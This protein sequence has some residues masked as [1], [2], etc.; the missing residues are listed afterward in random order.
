MTTIGKLV[1]LIERLKE[2]NPSI[3][4]ELSSAEIKIYLGQALNKLL[5]V[6]QLNVNRPDSENFPPHCMIATYENIPVFPY[7]VNRSYAVLPAYPISLP[8]NKGVWS[9]APSTAPDN[10][11]IPLESGQWNLIQGMKQLSLL[12]SQTGYEVNSGKIVFT[13]NITTGT[14][15][16]VNSVTVQL[17]IV[18]VSTLG[19][20]DI[21]PIPVD[22]EEAVVKEV[23]SII[24]NQ[25]PQ[26]R[27]NN[28]ADV[29]T[30]TK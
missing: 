29:K 14:T 19:D 1:E 17:L 21:L 8:R 27:D 16:N 15:N 6:E 2:G 9:V 12:A 13:K 24:M 4:A 11:Y 10:Y 23:F 18:D 20:Y 7:N 3:S 28:S 25:P 26:V 30:I 22:M 5:K